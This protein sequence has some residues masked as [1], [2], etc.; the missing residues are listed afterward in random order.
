S[1]ITSVVCTNNDDCSVD[2][3]SQCDTTNGK[4]ECKT[5]FAETGT[6]CEL[7]SITSV[8]CTNNDDCSVDDNSQCDT[9]NGKCE[10]KTGFAV[11][12]TKCELSSI[13]SVVCTNNDGCSV[14]DNSQCDTTNGKCECKTGFAVTGTKCELSSITSVVCTDNDGCSVDGN[15]QCD[16][17][18]GKCECKTGFAVTGTKCELSSITSVV[19][20]NNDGCSVDDNSQCDTTNGKC[21]CKTGFAVTGTKCEQM[22]TSVA[23]NDG[24]SEC[25]IDTNSE[26][27]T[28]KKSCVC[29]AGFAVVGARCEDIDE[30]EEKIDEC[31]KTNGK[32]TN[33]Q[34][35][36]TCECNSDYNGDGKTCTRI[37]T[38][39][40]CTESSS[41]CNI[42]VNSDCDTKSRL[43]VCKTGYEVA[44]ARCAATCSKGPCQNGATCTVNS[45]QL[46][47][48]CLAGYEGD[49][50]QTGKCLDT[51]CQNGGKCTDTDNKVVCECTNGFQ[52]DYCQT[53]VAT[54]PLSYGANYGQ[55][56]ISYPKKRD[57]CVMVDN[58][59]CPIKV[60]DEYRNKFYICENGIVTFRKQ[61]KKNSVPSSVSERNKFK[62]RDIVAPYFSNIDARTTGDIW[63]RLYN[64]DELASD[65]T[66]NTE[67]SAILNDAGYGSMDVYFLLVVTWADVVEYSK[68]T[69]DLTST[70]QLII[71]S[72][73]K[74]NTFAFF[75]YL[76]DKMN[77]ATFENQIGIAFE[78]QQT[79]SVR[80]RSPVTRYTNLGRSGFAMFSLNSGWNTKI[81]DCY[82]CK[83][84]TTREANTLK[85]LETRWNDMPMCPC[86]KNTI[87]VA[88]FFEKTSILISSDIIDTYSIKSNEEYNYQGMT[89]TYESSSFISSGDN[90]GFRSEYNSLTFGYYAFYNAELD[91]RSVCCKAGL[92]DDFHAVRP[93]NTNCTASAGVLVGGGT[94]DPHITTP[95]G[96]SFTFNGEAEYTMLSVQKEGVDFVLQARTAPFLSD[97]GTS[98]GATVFTAFA[99]K[100]NID[101]SR[102][103]IE[104]NNNTDAGMQIKVNGKFFTSEFASDQQFSTSE[105]AVS[106]EK[107][108]G[109]I[110]VSFT[111][112]KISFTVAVKLKRLLTISVAVPETYAGLPKG[113]MGNANSDP[114]DDFTYPNGTVLPTNATEREIF[115][116]GQTWMIT[117]SDE[118]VFEYPPGGSFLDFQN[119][120][121]TVNFLDEADQALVTEATT[122]CGEG[123]I[124]CIFDK[125]F[126]GNDEVAEDTKSV[127]KEQEDI[128]LRLENVAPTL[129]LDVAS[130][131][132]NTGKI[133]V[134]NETKTEVTLTGVDDGVITFQI[135]SGADIATL[136]DG[137]TNNA[138]VL[139]IS[140]QNDTAITISL[141][142]VDNFQVQS[143]LLVL[144]IIL[145]TGCNGNGE[146]VYTNT[147]TP[148][149]AVQGFN[150][151]LCDCNDFYEGDE[152]GT[153]LDGCEGDPCSLDRECTDNDAATHAE[154]E[155]AFTCGECPDGYTTDGQDCLDINECEAEPKPCSD[156][157]E[158]TVGSYVCKCNEGRRAKN[159][160]TCIDIN[161]C[162]EATSNCEQI[163]TNIDPGFTCSCNDGYDYDATANTCTLSD[164]AL[165]A[166]SGCSTENGGCLVEN[167]DT[168]CF[169]NKGYKLGN[170]EKSFVND[171]LLF[172]CLDIDECGQNICSGT[173][174][175]TAGSYTCGCLTGFTLNADKTTCSACLS[176]FWG[177]DCAQ[178]CTCSS[179]GSSDCDN[180]KGCIC[181][182][183]WEGTDCTVNV[184]ECS[185]A[186][187]CNDDYKTCVDTLGSYRCDCIQHY[188]LNT[189]TDKCDDIN[190]C[191]DANLNNCQQQCTNTDGGFVCECFNGYKKDPSDA[192]KCIDVDECDIGNTGCQQTCENTKGSYNCLCYFG[193]SLNS[194]QKSCT[195][196]SAD[197][198]CSNQGLTCDGYC[199]V[200]T[201]TAQ[202]ACP[203]GSVLAADDKQSCIDINEC[204][205]STLNKC[206]YPDTCKNVNGGFTC[207]CPTGKFL[208]HDGITCTVCDAFHYGENC[209]QECKCGVGAA[210]CDPITGCVC[211]DGWTS[212]KCD[213]DRNECDVATSPCTRVNTV[214]TNTPGG[215]TCP[216]KEGYFNNTNG[217]CE[218]T[219]ECNNPQLNTCTQICDNTLGSY[220]CSCRD[221]YIQDGNGCNDIDECSGINDCSQICNNFDGS[222]KC[223]CNPGYILS[224]EDQKTCTV[225]TECSTGNRCGA[226]TD[227]L[228]INNEESCPCKKGFEKA[229]EADTSCTDIDE[230]N[231]THPCVNGT[232]NNND[233]GFTCSCERGFK[234]DKDF[235]TCTPCQSGSF[236]VNCGET[237]ACKESNTETCNADTGAC[238]CKTG[239]K[240]NDCGANIDE[241]T[242]NTYQ[243]N[244]SVNSTCV[245]TEGS[246]VCECVDGF[247]KNSEKN[248]EVCDS[249]HF[250]KN[251]AQECACNFANTETC[252]SQNGSC[253][254]MTSWKGDT[255]SE[256]VDEC[257]TTNPC[258]ETHKTQCSNSAG[259]YTCQCDSG[260]EL[261]EDSC[262]DTNECQRGTSNCIQKCTNTEGSFNCS[263]DIGHSGTDNDCTKCAVDKWGEQCA[264]D[265][266]CDEVR[267]SGCDHVTGCICNPGWQGATCTEDVDECKTNTDSCPANSLC[268]NTVGSHTCACKPGYDETL[269]GC[270]EC[271]K[272]TYGI[273]CNMTCDCDADHTLTIT[274]TCD[275]TN[276]TCLCLPTWTGTRCDI[277]V[278]EC[279]LNTHNCTG[280]YEGCTN[281]NDGFNCSCWRGYTRHNNGT[282]VL[283]DTPVPT[284]TETPADKRKI[285]VLLTLAIDLPGGVDFNVGDTY[286]TYSEEVTNELTDL[287]KRTLPARTEFIIN[288]LNLTRGSLKV[289]YEVIVP[290]AAVSGVAVANAKIATGQESLQIFNNNATAT[291]LSINGVTVST[292]TEDS[293]ALI[294]TLF[295]AASGKCSYRCVVTDDKP[296]CEAEDK[297]DHLPLILG[298][299]VGVPMFFIIVAIIVISIFYYHFRKQR[300]SSEDLRDF[301]EREMDMFA[302]KIPRRINTG[303][304]SG[305]LSGTL[306]LE[307][308]PVYPEYSMGKSQHYYDRSRSDYDNAREPH[309]NSNFSWD[310]LFRQMDQEKPFKI[311]RPTVDGRS[312]RGNDMY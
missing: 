119:L 226:N 204:E 127:S 101:N 170:D 80:V 131:D 301:D 41:E 211:K 19:C 240:G 90:V 120:N 210:R 12:G 242:D 104:L 56:K 128:Q 44:G 13:T 133:H 123:N 287:Y 186:N 194:D 144:D 73:G 203:A 22:I 150:L 253:A 303:V 246:Y 148:D 60:D 162:E 291:N 50:C 294:C 250:G 95:D 258:T 312:P 115:N 125:V 40:Q 212:E 292:G 85:V 164:T 153:D 159:A 198:I 288:I 154:T 31:D 206:E 308:Y 218:D 197:T 77:F 274:Q 209:L 279:T 21:E 214:C 254:C 305:P 88:G 219:D 185:V 286:K 59:E 6:K 259:S 304:Y 241:C 135:I 161:E 280:M 216:C 297:T 26:C 284:T 207:T 103:T 205:D 311:K 152:C 4:C 282:C 275:T 2:H 46:V 307:D 138:K 96:K 70:F 29:Q 220:T 3:N 54:L 30:C 283:D 296:A 243:H 48:S 36:Y 190:E 306:D 217:Q 89:C 106:L 293:D 61:Y 143:A 160:T 172:Y 298:L 23:C 78:F 272:N 265:C 33:T 65:T 261:D 117:S 53:R 100:D 57:W 18:N 145:C 1:S 196:L 168:K 34:G 227:C 112:S 98:V 310:Y 248:C 136:R 129:Q 72:D 137:T 17:T 66:V 86:D 142:A 109:S 111:K 147:R 83:Q 234:L 35:S 134:L 63:Y 75:A 235:I 74:H 171:T 270:I 224:E 187:I 167:G 295:E 180:A 43:C 285:K 271:T 118:S 276:G 289:E 268:T 195:Q 178:T 188:Q 249:K 266:N 251:C 213:L 69:N 10:C 45:N 130:L 52:G 141:V 68:D 229:D 309:G 58:F 11:T 236:G 9:T 223:S 256:D 176:G 260:F 122:F 32:C 20:T 99:A 244:C 62:N 192:T 121:P 189:E 28:T 182:A 299:G 239:W 15:S 202:C 116:Y 238:T 263:C 47:C 151:A 42:D 107:Q 201:A 113:L 158:N 200:G 267:S 215:F 92:C 222:Y 124:P 228:M 177:N 232:C 255:C 247:F 221:G 173:C 237:C 191:N 273:G 181:K 49:Y 102:C 199:R 8:V 93:R 82:I 39:V 38:T 87:Q 55:L 84:W 156:I 155:N 281:I 175:N 300:H 269:S 79:L 24:G 231:S 105:G 252:D 14:D 97:D 193:Y 64:K 16:T 245:D 149:P 264:T 163:C 108:N 71:V 81:S 166:T 257:S 5:G 140:F 114:S 233:G 183:G 7:S 277:N 67:I 27:D 139:E 230:C 169:C 208:E 94:G 76:E 262:V 157:C 91:M 225:Q 302:G 174:D 146:C 165:C 37:I 290:T 110:K 51:T 179:L 278:D 25:N 132:E 126:T 184:N